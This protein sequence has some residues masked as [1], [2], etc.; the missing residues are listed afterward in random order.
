VE[1]LSR[2]VFF[3]DHKAL[4]A[5][6]AA[7]ASSP[8]SVG[9]AAPPPEPELKL[10]GVVVTGDLRRAYLVLKSGGDGIWVE[11]GEEIRGWRINA[12]TRN[13]LTLQSDSHTKQLMLYER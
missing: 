4:Y 10:A 8:P 7:R 5:A 9:M 12:I 6:T 2:P 3:K 11:E 13:G 1:T